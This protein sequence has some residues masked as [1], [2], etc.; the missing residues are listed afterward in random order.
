MS[1]VQNNTGKMSCFV[2]AKDLSQKLY[3]VVNMNNIFPVSN[4]G[5]MVSYILQKFNLTC[6]FPASTISALAPLYTTI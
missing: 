2:K 4:T 3:T 5:K 6:I 1:S